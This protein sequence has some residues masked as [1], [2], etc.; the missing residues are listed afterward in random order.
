MADTWLPT[1]IT[2]GPQEGFQLAMTLSRKVI[3]LTQP[4]AEVRRGLRPVYS[5]DAES[6]IATSQ[7]VAT[8][9]KTIAAANNYWRDAAQSVTG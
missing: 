4:D 9:F 3:G 7:V 1:L 8:N 2:A 6:L 5:A